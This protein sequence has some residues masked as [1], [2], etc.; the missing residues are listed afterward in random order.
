MKA[1]LRESYKADP[2]KKVSVRDN[3]NAD[4]PIDLLQLA[5]FITSHVL[6]SY[7]CCYK[8]TPRGYEISNNRTGTNDGG[9]NML[10]CSYL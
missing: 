8:Y 7:V 5:S 1:S 2:E 3:Y 6:T 9:N 10:T 4:R